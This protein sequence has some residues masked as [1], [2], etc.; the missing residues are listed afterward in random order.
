MVS[1]KMAQDNYNEQEMELLKDKKE[2]KNQLKDKHV[3]HQDEIKTIR[4]VNLEN[5]HFI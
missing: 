2:L 4:M 1:L 5:L 3:E